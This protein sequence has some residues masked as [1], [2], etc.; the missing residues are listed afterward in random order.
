[1]LCGPMHVL[2]CCRCD[3]DLKLGVVE[4]KKLKK[5]GKKKLIQEVPGPSS[6]GMY[7]AAPW[8]KGI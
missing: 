3:Q 5:K 1:M 6:G 4:E 2:T 8:D 7:G